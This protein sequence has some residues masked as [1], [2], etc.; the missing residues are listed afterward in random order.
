MTQSSLQSLYVTA[1]NQQL[2]AAQLATL[3]AELAA[4]GGLDATLGLEFL[5]LGPDTVRAQ[6]RVDRRHLQPWGVANGGLYCSIGESVASIAGFV[7]TGGTARVMGVNNSTNF[8]APTTPGDVLVATAQALQTGRT[9]QVW[10]VSI[11][12]KAT[13][14]LVAKTTLRTAVRP[15]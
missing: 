11:K 12:N 5:D 1:C 6:L 10:E 7:A 13:S 4:H 15:L 8:F 2:D 9:T 3:N 14:V